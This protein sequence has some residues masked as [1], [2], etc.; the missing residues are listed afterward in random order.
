MF[1]FTPQC[2][3]T[4]AHCSNRLLATVSGLLLLALALI[5]GITPTLKAQVLYGSIVGTVRDAT[6]A[7]VPGAN[8]TVTETGTN[9]SRSALTNENGGYTLSTV[10][11]GDYKVTISKEGFKLYSL[12]HIPVG[13]NSVVRVDAALQVGVLTETVQVS[14]QSAPLQTDKVDVHL[15]FSS[16]QIEELPQAT[17]QFGGLVALVPGATPMTTMTGGFNNPSKPLQVSVNGTSSNGSNTLIDGISATNPWIQFVSMYAPS[18][19]ALESVNFVTATSGADVGMTNG[20]SMNLQT[21]SGTNQIHGSAYEYHINSAFQSRAFFLPASQGIPKQVNNDYG[22]TVGGPIR[23][24]KL[25]F[26][27]SY[28]RDALRQG[29]AK[30]QTIPTAAIRSGNMSA[31]P[32]TIYDPGTG[33]YDASGIPSGRTPFPLNIIPSGRISPVAAKMVALLPDPNANL[34]AAQPSNNFYV[35]TPLSNT[36]TH[37]DTKADWVF[38]DRLKINGRFGHMPFDV[39]QPAVFGPILGGAAAPQFQTGY[40]NAFA[41]AATFI[42]TPTFVADFNFGRTFAHQQQLPSSS[43]QRVGLDYFGIAGANVGALPYGGSLAQIAIANYSTYGE[44]WTA[45]QYDDPVYQYTGNATWTKSKHSLRFGFNMSRQHMSHSEL[46]PTPS[47]SF[48]GNATT[49]GKGGANPN[50]FNTYADFLLGYAQTIVNTVP[51]EKPTLLYTPQYSLYLQDTWQVHHMLTLTVGSNWEYYPIPH[52]DDRQ[53]ETWD[54]A[55]SKIILCGQGNNPSNCGITVQKTLFGPRIGIAYR[56]TESVVIR[57]GYSLAPEQNNMFRD[58]M[59]NYPIQ[60]KY[61]QSGNS[62]WQ[63]VGTFSTGMP[64]PAP[65]IINNGV[66][67]PP[68]GSFLNT[69][70]PQNRLFKRGYTESMNLSVQK[71]FGHGW[72]GQVAYVGTWTNHQ[73][74]K[75]NV[76]NATVLNGGA[77]S[78]VFYPLGITAGMFEILPYIT[79]RYHSLQ[80]TANHRFSNGFQFGAA[81]TFSKWMGTC[82]NEN[83]GGGPQITMPQYTYLNWARMPNDRPHNLRLSGNYDLPFGRGHNMAGSGLAAQVIGGWHLNGVFGSYSG[84]PFSISGGNLNTPGFTQRGQQVKQDVQYFGNVGPG[85]KFFDTTAF[86]AAPNGVIGNSGYSNMRGPGVVNLDLSIFRDFKPT[87]RLTF[88]FRG[89]ALNATNTPHFQNPDGNVTSSTFGEVKAAASN[90]SG[91]GRAMDERYLRIGLKILF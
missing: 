23:K 86:V 10:R 68:A 51:N 3:G 45:I 48:N 60:L 90:G 13:V 61:V 58:G 70:I 25:F 34:S 33:T 7:V 62:T 30:F 84:L 38:S 66:V 19:E 35:N 8:V 85:Q 6:G 53:I 21:K 5:A 78:Q 28:E 27:G 43:D 29:S 79:M 11:S 88:Q 36:L 54:Y 1:N 9:D 17:R 65:A 47:F 82:C 31:S 40:A 81:Y 57:A 15:E 14:G 50:S 55:T 59:Y 77:T 39:T 2:T 72:V 41:I 73:H 69:I 52:R 67:T 83:G 12:T 44:N 46:N 89:E 87:E 74:T 75:Y 20:V 26:F 63:P 16:K 32:A 80:A 22:A 91:T 56:P 76:N 37:F 42:A 49:A 71:E 64:V 18:V 24:N 4:V